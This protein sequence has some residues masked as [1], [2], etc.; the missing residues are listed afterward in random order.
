MAAIS[1]VGGTVAAKARGRKPRSPRHTFNIR[2]RPWQIQPFF[3]APVLPGETMKNLLVQS[4]VV[5]DPIKHPL[6]GWWHEMMF[7]YVKHRDLEARDLITSMHIDPAADLSGLASAADPLHYHAGGVNWSALCLKRVVDEY[8][9]DEDEEAS[10][11]TIGG[12]PAAN[13]NNASVMHSLT[14]ESAMPAGSTDDQE[15]PGWDPEIPDD[16]PA[17]FEQH[18]RMWEHMKAAKVIDVDFAAYLKSFGV[19][20]A[21]ELRKEEHHRPELLR[22]TRDWQYPSNTI[23]PTTGAPSSA[24]SWVIGERADKDRFFAEPGFLFGVMVTRPKVYL[25]NQKGSALAVMTDAFS[26]LPAVLADEAYTSLKEIVGTAGPI[27]G[28]QAGDYW[29]DLRDLF[30]HGDQFINYA[31]AGQP[32]TVALPTAALEQKYA[33]AA[34]ADALFVDPLKNLVRVDG[35]V[36]LTIHGRAGVD[37]TP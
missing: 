24:V 22:M 13:I 11:I 6:I 28:L 23:E 3:I 27:G 37:S 15:L 8:F 19:S 21:K 34:D 35:V 25:G 26:W 29:L 36:S 14:L 1:I 33:T 9:R 32:G 30:I 12:L 16:V 5:T 10:A 18:F 4:R 20:P 31:P 7:F 2:H 17:G